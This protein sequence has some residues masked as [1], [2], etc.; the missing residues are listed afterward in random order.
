[1]DV[2]VKMHTILNDATMETSGSKK[3]VTFK[4]PLPPPKLATSS[5]T[6]KQTPKTALSPR[7]IA[8]AIINKPLHTSDIIRGPVT[9]SRYAQ[10][11]A[12]IINK[13]DKYPP[14]VALTITEL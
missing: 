4:D 11:L 10:V 5:S 3:K 7:V 12:D 14:R 9:R 13:N 2:L 1:M 6:L 8:K